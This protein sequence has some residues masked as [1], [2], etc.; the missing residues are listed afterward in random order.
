MPHSS[1]WH[2]ASEKKL[3]IF[4]AVSQNASGLSSYTPDNP[5]DF[6]VV[7]VVEQFTSCESLD[8][9]LRKHCV[10]VNPSHGSLHVATLS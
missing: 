2:G 10:G 5:Q 3:I 4:G 7:V 6:F 1:G 9:P 8:L